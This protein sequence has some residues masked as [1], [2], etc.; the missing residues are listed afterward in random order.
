MTG[1]RT[2]RLLQ[3]VAG[4]DLVFALAFAGAFEST[5][6]LDFVLIAGVLGAGALGMFMYAHR[7]ARRL[8][9]Q[10]ALLEDGGTSSGWWSG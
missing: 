9:E 3:T 8:A 7:L 5:G 1:R 4:V 6:R 2:P 10:R